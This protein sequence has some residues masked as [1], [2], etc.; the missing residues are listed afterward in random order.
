MTR[1]AERSRARQPVDR[2][3]DTRWLT[4]AAERLQTTRRHGHPD[5]V[6]PTIGLCAVLDA[7]AA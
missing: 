3:P 6:W 1:S 7:Q 4:A 5:I 2:R